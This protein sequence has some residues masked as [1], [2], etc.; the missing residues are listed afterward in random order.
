M[1]LTA[2]GVQRTT[3]RVGLPKRA[4]ERMVQRVR[5]RGI[6]AEHCTGRLQA[7]LRNLEASHGTTAA[8]YGEHVYCFGVGQVLVTVLFLPH[9]LR[10]LA[11]KVTR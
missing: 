4:V 3:E 11:R 6:R 9:E 2:H 8:I 1:S 10:P 7:Y 5:D